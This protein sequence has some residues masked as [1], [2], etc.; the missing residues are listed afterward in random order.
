[1]RNNLPPVPYGSVFFA[2]MEGITDEAFRKTILKLYPEWDYLACDFL[3]VP[4]AGKYPTKHLVRHMGK[5][6]FE[7]GWI[8]DKTM[9][10]I[11]TS[12]RAFTTQMVQDLESLDIPWMDLNLGCPSPTVCKN[13]G[14]SF[15]LKDLSTLRPLIKNIREIF[16]GRFTT[17]IRV[18]FE[19]PDGL[20]DIIKMLNDEGVE[21]IT[22]HGR[23]REQMYKE[24]ANWELIRKA[25]QA[26]QVPIIGNGDV[27]KT[28]DIDRM[29]SETGCHGVMVARGALKSPWM[30]QDYRRAI[31]KETAEDRF[32]KIKTF[33][34]EYRTLLESENISERGLLK[35]S[36]SVS[37]YMVEGMDGGEAIRRKL[38]LSQ[39]APDFF[40]VIDSF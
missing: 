30:A 37:R 18:G 24:P 34:A 27:W 38:I 16:K 20:L 36:K 5:E 29:L 32:K 40:S 22:V 33:F 26:S 21:M 2:P 3:R 10:Q 13:G 28:E 19:N 31:F 8:K 17:K 25:V 14:G 15:L 4:S 23:T 6:L 1:M 11:L 35:Q 39:T 12:H 7:I 9:Y